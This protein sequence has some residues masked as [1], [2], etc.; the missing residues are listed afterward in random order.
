M[1]RD[2]QEWHSAYDDP[3]SS[4][5]QRLRVVTAMIRSHLD[6]ARPGPIRILSLC[7]G[8]GRDLA[9]AARGHTRA[10]DLSGCLVELDPLLAERAR[11][12]LRSAE[13]DVAVLCTDAGSSANFV[14]LGP[15]DLLLLVGIFG[16]VSDDD[17]H[18][19]ISAVPALCRSGA[20][21][22]WT[23]HRRD[24]DLTG[25][26]RDWF[27]GVGCHAI[28]FVSDGV[29]RFAVGSECF[30]KPDPDFVGSV[31]PARLFA[32]RDDLW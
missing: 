11:V 7:A 4:L 3:T 18:R 23:R 22:L 8:D 1:V 25:Q 13:V 32:F 16:N 21:V 15:V 10:P 24:P 9:D 20:T 27:E 14:G 12:N 6:S 2:W 30:E 29:G 28:S 26:I 19:T 31:M 17:V 5:S